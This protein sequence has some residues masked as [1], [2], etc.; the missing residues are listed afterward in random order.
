M[1][2]FILPVLLVALFSACFSSVGSALADN[3]SDAE[4]SEALAAHN[5]VRQAVAQAES[6]RLGGTVVIPD[7]TW[8]AG[9]A[10]V[11]QDWAD[12]Q[13]AR[14]QQGLPPE[15]RPN[16]AYGE[17]M[18]WAWS[19]PDQPDLSPTAAVQ[20]WASEQQYYDYDTNT[21]AAGEQCG[22]YTQL[23]WSTTTQ[24]GCGRSVWTAT[25]GMHHVLWVC[26]YAPAGN[27]TINGEKLR[28]YSVSDTPPPGTGC[29]YNWTRTLE[30]GAQGEDV[31][32]LQRRLN[33]AGA[34]LYVDGDFGPVTDQAVR[35]FQ[36]ANRLEVD[37]IVG[38]ET[39]AALNQVCSE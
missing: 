8:D 27:L 30:I 25:D 37:G 21:C 1:R 9:V 11:A 28:P 24:V 35:D 5:A 4:T 26:N 29:A 17:N 23:V 34:D 18:Y 7:L 19:T 16:N 10:A 15:H 20:W 2:R 39:Q 13:A 12:Q 36:A 14:L 22:H 33:A 6:M 3:L 38:P 31:A 32:E